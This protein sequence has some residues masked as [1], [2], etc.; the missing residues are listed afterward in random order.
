MAGRRYFIAM[1]LLNEESES[2]IEKK[3][4]TQD[5]VYRLEGLRYDG[6]PE[7]GGLA[8]FRGEL[9]TEAVRSAEAFDW[10]ADSLRL[11][12]RQDEFLSYQDVVIATKA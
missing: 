4:S 2:L 8:G 6:S 7:S 12:V 11:V 5:F 3:R 10:R 1:F 9:C